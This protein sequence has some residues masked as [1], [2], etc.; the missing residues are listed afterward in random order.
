[1]PLKELRGIVI[2]W[3]ANTARGAD[4]DAHQRYFNTTTRM[5]SAHYVVDDQQVI[6]LIPDT[7]VA[8]HVGDRK[9]GNIA[10]PRRAQ[11]LRDAHD[12][13]SQV[14][15]LYTIGVELCV[16]QYS[17]FMRTAEY[18]AQLTAMLLKR[19]QLTIADLYRHVDLTGKDCPNMYLNHQV[20]GESYDWSWQ[21][22]LALVDVTQERMQLSEQQKALNDR[23]Y[24]LMSNTNPPTPNPT[25]DPPLTAWDHLALFFVKIF[26][27][28]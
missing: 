19:H 12:P 17:D 13:G 9:R 1:M 18:A 26:E 22:F 4:A 7:E 27:K 14:P 3:T 16:N 28:K 6:Q 21:T 10:Y 2:H 20:A 23:L 11:L 25:P 5:A 8:Y 24:E 15:N